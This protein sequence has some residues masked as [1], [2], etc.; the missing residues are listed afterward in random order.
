MGRGQIR[1]DSLPR[2]K[3]DDTKDPQ[4]KYCSLALISNRVQAKLHTKKV[5][6]QP[7]FNTCVWQYST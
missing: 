4:I 5:G 3:C 6:S 7:L 2:S 1:T